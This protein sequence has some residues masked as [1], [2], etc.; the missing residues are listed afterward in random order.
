MVP[1]S[2]LFY[3]YYQYQYPGSLHNVQLP[4]CACC[5]PISCIFSSRGEFWL[6]G[7]LVMLVGVCEILGLLPP[8]A[9][10][11]WYGGSLDTG[12]GVLRLVTWLWVWGRRAQES[13]F[14]PRCSQW[15]YR[16][17]TEVNESWQSITGCTADADNRHLTFTAM[18]SLSEG[19]GLLRWNLPD[20]IRQKPHCQQ[21]GQAGEESFKLGNKREREMTTHSQVRKWGNVLTNKGHRVMQTRRTLGKI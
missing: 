15:E 14:S 13:R 2:C 16:P 6:R 19:Q 12:M 9:Y 1:L 8:T 3:Q 21:A 20:Q 18:E 10:L 7:V 5:F 11:P 17:W 4:Y